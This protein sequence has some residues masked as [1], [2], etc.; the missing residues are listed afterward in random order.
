MPVFTQLNGDAGGRSVFVAKDGADSGDVCRISEME[1]EGDILSDG[2]PGDGDFKIVVISD[3]SVAG[4]PR[5]LEAANGSDLAI[6]LRVELDGEFLPIGRYDGNLGGLRWSGI[7]DRAG[8]GDAT[9]FSGFP[10]GRHS[11]ALIPVTG[12][13]LE[14]QMESG[15][16]PVF[17]RCDMESEG[18]AA[19]PGDEVE[20]RFTIERFVIGIAEV[21]VEEIVVLH[22]TT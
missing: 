18:Q 10:E 17:R 7:Q 8:D 1:K 13:S 12:L 3:V 22:K 16:R 21:E 2:A 9:F 14:S 6:F 15:F 5:S 11:F 19:G 4:F 20:T